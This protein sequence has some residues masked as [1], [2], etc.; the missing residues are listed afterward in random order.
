QLGDGYRLLR[1]VEARLRLLNTS[2]RHDLPTDPME[3]KKLAYL[4]GYENVEQLAHETD[5]C[6]RQNRK[7]FEQIVREAAN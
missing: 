5:L 1:E 6:R 4:L 3:Q 7:L 2:A